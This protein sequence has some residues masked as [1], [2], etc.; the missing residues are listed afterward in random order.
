MGVTVTN[1]TPANGVT[2][3]PGSR[4]LYLA[5]Q[6]ESDET[7]IGTNLLYR[8]NG[9]SWVQ[10]Y[11]ERNSQS[12]AVSKAITVYAGDVIEWYVIISWIKTAEPG[13]IYIYYAPTWTLYGRNDTTPPVISN[14]S[15]SGGDVA[16]GGD[17]VVFS[18]QVSDNYKLSRVE[19][20]ID[21]VLERTWDTTASSLAPSHAKKLALGAHSF[22]FWARDSFG[23]TTTSPTVNFTVVN[24]APE[25][26]SGDISVNGQT[27]SVE[28]ANLGSVLVEWPAFLDGNPEDT[29][30]YDLE[31]RVAGGSWSVYASGLTGTSTYWT[32]NLGLGQVELRV[33]AYDGT[34][35]S[36][37]L[38]RTGITVVS[39]QS[40][41]TPTLNAPSGTPWREGERRTISWT[42]ASPEHPE[43]LP[44][45]YRLQFSAQGDF[46]DAVEIASGLTGTSYDWTLPTSLVDSDIT[47]CKIRLRAEDQYAK[48]SDWSVSDAFTVL[49]NACPTIS[50]VDPTSEGYA[51]GN[52]PYLVFEVDD[53]D[54]GDK[55]H[56][57]LELS[58]LP[59]FSGATSANSADDQTGWE[60]ST[61]PYTTWTSVPSEGVSPG[62]RV[63]WKAGP[64]RYDFY[65]L[66]ARVTDG[67]LTSDWTSPVRFLVTPSGEAPLTCTIGES[68][69]HIANLRV[70][71]RTGG[72]P[73]PLEFDV[74]LNE[75]L[76]APIACG[77]P[78][79]IALC[80]E[81]LSRTWNATVESI[82]SQGGVVHVYCLQDDAY[83]SRKVVAGDYTSDDV[84][85]NLA[86]MID[87][88]GA[89]LDSS[90]IDT[91]LDVEAPIAGEYRSLAAHLAE[92]AEIVGAVFWV[93]STGSVHFVKSDELPEPEYILYEP[94]EV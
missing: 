61:A 19:L 83:L 77:A 87:D 58:L 2:V 33:R 17:G 65:Y 4:T 80:I 79:S 54:S 24:G 20:Y 45:T 23:N 57:E 93:D 48:V 84:G 9:G 49:E 88:Y 6:V 21:G 29:L 8:R 35:Y 51:A 13:T 72:E 40:P 10:S 73:S 26:P 71:E 75:Y 27:G 36:D 91:T 38:V 59:T 28:V 76:A 7:I 70:T 63:R 12:V 30:T 39:S 47:T 64:L 85:V 92:W 69:Y 62:C 94:F 14:L 16:P 60:Q 52:E 3:D 18:C 53:T 32:P 55:L 37:Y 31:E 68:S 50:V 1:R 46:T 56:V 82:K 81:D 15:P 34:A 22:Y 90:G 41:N 11:Q 86:A 74:S 44:V 25:P 43:G 89:P 67:I 66:R 42:P 5:A 78:V